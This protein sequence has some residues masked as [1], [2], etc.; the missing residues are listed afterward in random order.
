VDPDRWLASIHGQA[1]ARTVQP[2]GSVVVEHRHYYIKQSA[3]RSLGII[4]MN[5]SGASIRKERA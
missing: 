5:K 2:N 4:D 1:F 3:N